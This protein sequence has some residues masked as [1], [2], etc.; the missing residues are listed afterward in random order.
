MKTA[1]NLLFWGLLFVML[2]IDIVIDLF[3]DPIGHL[4][5]ALGCFKLQDKF[6]VAQRAGTF[7][8][9]MIFISI[10]MFFVNADQ[11]IGFGWHIYS[12]ALLILNLILVYFIF[13]VLKVIVN[14][15]DNK[16]LINR[17]YKTFNFYMSLSL[18]QLAFLSFSINI[19]EDIALTIAFIL[20]IAVFIMNIVFLVLI[21]A[22][23]QVEHFHPTQTK[24][25]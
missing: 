1:L 10:P 7:A 20:A 13:S 15:Y 22:I 16:A 4:L 23:R 3:P 11:A 25:I 21:R 18:I 24:I 19:H 12:M 9:I 17:T 2:R 5:I 6:P 8:T 14:N